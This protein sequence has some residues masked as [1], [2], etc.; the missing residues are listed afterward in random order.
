MRAKSSKQRCPAL[1][2]WWYSNLET[3]TRTK[4]TWVHNNL[5]TRP[6]ALNLAGEQSHVLTLYIP[7]Y[8]YTLFVPGGQICPPI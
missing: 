5:T 3:Q 4:S 2:P 1:C 7:G 6:F 8:F